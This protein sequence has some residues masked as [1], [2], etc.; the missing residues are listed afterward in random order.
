MDILID[1]RTPDDIWAQL[2]NELRGAEV[3]GIDC[4]TQD[5]NRHAGLNVF[6]NAKRHVFDHRRT[7]MTGFSLH[8]EGRE[9]SYYINLAHAD[10]ENRLPLAR[11]LEI[12]K[13][14][15]PKAVKVA[16][17]ASFEYVMFHQC[18]GVEFD[19]LVCTMQMAVSHHSPQQFDIDT[20]N[21]TQLVHLL[22][23]VKPI[24][25]A[26]ADYDT[27]SRGRNLT[28]EQSELLGKF[29]GK[30]S[31]SAASYNGFAKE[32]AFGYGLKKLVA[33]L[34]G[35]QM[36]TYKETLATAGATHMGELTGEQVVDY[37][38]DDAYQAVRLYRYFVT[39]MLAK[40]P[41][42]LVTFL[43]QENP[44]VKV[45]ADS[46]REG[47]R[48]NFSEVVRMRD[49]EREE[50]AVVC[51]RL[52]ANMRKLLPFAPGKNE[53]LAEL[54]DWYEKHWGKKRTQILGWLGS[55]DS[56]DAFE[57]VTQFSNPIGN[58]WTEEKGGTV[59]KN[60]LNLTHYHA[61]R[62]ILYDLM[63]AK[64][65]RYEGKVASDADA[66]GTIRLRMEKEG[67]KEDILAV[68][69][70]LQEMADI[71]Q[72][73]KLYLTPYTLL[74]DPETGRVYPSLTSE[75]AT[76]RLAASFPNP[77]QLAKNGGSSYIRG[78]YLGDT[79]EHLVISAD[80]SSIE[81]VLIGDFSDD[82]GFRQVFGQLPYGDLHSG[83]AADCL[84]VKTLPGLCEQEFKGFKFGENPNNRILKD[85]STGEVLSP[86]AFFKHARGGIGKGANFNYWYSGSLSTIAGNLGWTGDEMWEA[87][88]RYRGRFAVAE[89]WRIQQQVDGATHGFV[90]LPDG[91]QYSRYEA[92]DMWAEAMRWKFANLTPSPAL[93]NYGN[94]A[95]K[96]L[97]SRAK[98]QIVNAMIQG[99][100]A[101]LAKRSILNLQKL[102]AE[103][104]IQ[105]RVRFMMPIHDELVFS[106]HKDVVMIFIPLLRRAM[107][108]HSD[109]VK[110]FPLDCT[111]AI[112][113]T[114]KPFDGTAFSQWE[115]DEADCRGVENVIPVEFQGKKLPDEVIERVVRYL[116]AA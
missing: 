58:A 39:D 101:I 91:Q 63:D 73:M 80:W 74:A 76:R 9:D 106:V 62:T 89:A 7:V 47:L 72:R 28:K 31:T 20:F 88:D 114:F 40:N 18:L 65:I 59:L 45:Y 19:T 96:R 95:I 60:R 81:L 79:D 93:I 48:L 108:E 36:A 104:G 66:R 50:M 97:Q 32:I 24:Q 21:Q 103:A 64:I 111:F 42:A 34:F 90:T 113:R 17:N 10:K 37:G 77:M 5:E 3:I 14:I 44:M 43:K 83:A 1:A 27:D 78:F 54:E 98:N 57:Q 94:L 92:T 8:V 16:H 99:S 109:V 29:I 49:V 69:A 86:S 38:A 112:G 100:C 75:L 13:W 12:L 46:W 102:L 87:V 71:E 107:T 15:N 82:P 41:Q 55:P 26:F 23:L 67:G 33:S 4:E 53:K 116:A 35:V 11:G 115:L 105:D 51:R 25:R 70:D 84:A 110:H 30:T 52:K 68:L 85:T 6:N 61:M 56:E 22:P 2:E